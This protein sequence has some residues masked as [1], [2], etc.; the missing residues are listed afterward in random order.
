MLN[1]DSSRLGL[2]AIEK[3][4]G[5]GRAGSGAGSSLSGNPEELHVKCMHAQGVNGRWQLCKTGGFRERAF[6]SHP[7]CSCNYSVHFPRFQNKT[8]RNA[9]CSAKKKKA[10]DRSTD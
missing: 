7:G 2:F 10:S 6:G 4:A 3:A 8:F 1:T 5:C 9:S